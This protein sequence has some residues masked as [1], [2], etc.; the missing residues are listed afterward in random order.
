MK[1][2]SRN[3]NGINQITGSAV[4]ITVLNNDVAVFTTSSLNL[5]GSLTASSAVITGNVIVQGTA[6]INTLVVNQTQLS[7]GSNQL[8][9]AADDVQ[10][11]FG[12]VRIP[13]G[14][15][16]VTGSTII[17][18]SAA[19]QLQVGNNLLFVSSSGFVGIGVTPTTALQVL[20][21]TAGLMPK[22]Q[23]EVAAFE[24]NGDTKLGIYSSA[25]SITNIGSSLLLGMSNYTISSLY[26]GFEFQYVPNA[27]LA[28][29]VVKY[30]F[31]G[32]N[33]S[34]VVTSAAIDLFNI[35]Q[36][37]RVVINGSGIN[38]SANSKLLIG[39]STDA[40]FKLDVSGSSR[41]SGNVQITGSAT[42]SLIVR[43]SGAT[44]ATNA[45]L[46]Q[47]SSGNSSLTVADDRS[48]SIGSNLA[49]GGATLTFNSA[50][51]GFSA[52][53]NN[54]TFTGGH[55]GTTLTARTPTMFQGQYN[56]AV[57]TIGNTTFVDSSGI[58]T[59]LY[60]NGTTNNTGTSGYNGLVVNVT[61]TTTGSGAKS[62]FKAQQNSVD[63]FVITNSGNVGIGTSSPNF[64]LDVSGSSEFIGNMLLTGSLAITASASTSSAAL[65]VY[66][67]GSTVV[68]IQ[69]STGQ[70]FSIT[71]SLTG[72]LFSVNTVAGLPII[73]AFSDN[74]VNIGKFGSYPIRVVASGT[75]AS[76]T[77]SFTGSFTGSLFGSATSASFASTASLS[78][79]ALTAS[80]V[81]P[82]TQSV[83]IS[84]SVS[85]RGP[86]AIT[87]SLS[88]TGSAGTGSAFTVYK[89]GS[90]VVSIQGSQGELF[91]ITDSLS[92]SLFSVSNISGLPIL[93]VFSDNTVLLGSYLDPMLITTQRLTANSGSTVIYS[94]PTASYDGIF[95][96]YVI[97]SGS[98]A[99]AG[100]IM[101]M[102]SGSTAAYTDNSTTDFGST[103][104]FT[105]GLIVSGSNMVL[106]GSAST[107]GWT[108][109]AGI[110][111][112]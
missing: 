56:S 37:G 71:D 9:D 70:L 27:T 80:F 44:S 60:V 101:G 96:D 59:I 10:T 8:G 47:D 41:F 67:S 14:S 78:I 104:G 39:T 40:G 17:S 6:S 58:P 69:G 3:P 45:L 26:P 89:S 19:T 57:Y 50:Y 81:N 77:G 73:E 100:Q 51:Y 99:R 53:S 25:T 4:A 48:V 5:S 54:V 85:L 90:T 55:L 42:N 61:E 88:V 97:R 65:L 43:G 66:K 24:Y 33:S 18:S 63:R 16:N 36:D 32:R 23:Y 75:L 83:F 52:T 38:Y 102:W 11:L 1:Y 86:Q 21:G 108:V 49:V 62:L 68:D 93:E 31:V 29:N 22:N 28:N 91:S 87:G 74:T 105:F 46:I 92:G 7:T 12:T 110:R 111:S 76:I 34:G 84:G 79:T 95:V 82:L 72:S 109:R 20:R 94:L 107:S 103:S 35:Y 64:R 15:L 30:N 98:N 106:T 2:T 13:T 112:I